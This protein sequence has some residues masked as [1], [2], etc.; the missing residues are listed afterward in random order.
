LVKLLE[1]AISNIYMLIARA[2]INQVL[3]DL[4]INR[5]QLDEVI[6]TLK[7]INI[8]NSQDEIIVDLSNIEIKIK[9]NEKTP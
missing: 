5:K 1:R 4:K 7:N 8:N 9:K 6:A 2:V 3:N